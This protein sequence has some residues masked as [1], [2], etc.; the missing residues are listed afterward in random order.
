MSFSWLN[1]ITQ[2]CDGCKSIETK[3]EK[4]KGGCRLLSWMTLAV[5]AVELH[6]SH[7]PSRANIHHQ[8]LRT[9]VQ[10]RRPQ[11][12]PTWRWSTAE[13]GPELAI[14]Y[15]PE[16]LP[17]GS[18]CSRAPI[19]QLS[20]QNCSEVWSSSHPTVFLPSRDPQASELTPGLAGLSP[21]S[22]PLS[23]D[24]SPRSSSQT[25]IACVSD[26]QNAVKILLKLVL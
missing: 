15:A 2:P 5:A 1:L 9:H 8:A 25:Q 26:Q 7:L 4:T 3:N 10:A 13:A 11:G 14:P 17:T 18:S 12:S 23:S 16:P 6:Y 21:S 19:T 22:R 24:P 20:S